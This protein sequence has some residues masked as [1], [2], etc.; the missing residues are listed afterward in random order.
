LKWLRALEWLLELIVGLRIFSEILL[1][2]LSG[3]HGTDALQKRFVLD[4]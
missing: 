1:L 4:H 2:K 3:F